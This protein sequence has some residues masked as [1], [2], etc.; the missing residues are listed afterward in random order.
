MRFSCIVF[1][2]YAFKCCKLICQFVTARTNFLAVFTQ[3]SKN[4]RNFCSDWN[5]LLK[6]DVAIIFM[7]YFH[8]I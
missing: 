5:F 8:I 3:I 7:L 4:R 6:R 1:K 2:L